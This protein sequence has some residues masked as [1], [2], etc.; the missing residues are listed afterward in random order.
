MTHLRSPLTNVA[1][2][3]LAFKK[4]LTR[5]GL[6]I[7][8]Q[9]DISHGNLTVWQRFD[10]LQIYSTTMLNSFA[11]L[12][13]SKLCWQNVDNPSPSHVPTLLPQ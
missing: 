13:C 7:V 2:L 5:P 6:K 3:E 4:F 1:E 10:K 12:L 9:A 8:T 11:S